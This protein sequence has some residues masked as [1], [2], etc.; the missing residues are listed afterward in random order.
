MQ[1][2]EKI[3]VEKLSKDLRLASALMSRDEARFLVDAYYQIQEH[4][5]AMQAQAQSLQKNDEPNAYMSYIGAQQEM[6]EEQIKKALGAYAKAQPAGKWAMSVCGIGPI[7][8]AGLLAYINPDEYQYIGS[9]LRFGG[10]DSSITWEKGE[11]RPWAAGLKVLFFKIGESFIKVQNRDSD[12]YGKF[13]R[14][15]K[16]VYL[17][18][19]ERGEHAK[20]AEAKLEKFKIGK[21]TEAYKAYSQGQLPPAHIHARARRKAVQLF[22]SHFCQVQWES[23]HKKPFPRPWVFV[24]P[25]RP[26]EQGSFVPPPGYEPLPR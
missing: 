24:H 1:M 3:E 25:D 10:Y 16:D 9:V 7:I 13:Y 12:F 17:W 2:L 19:N 26:H 11:K 5:I 23:H 22:I 8:S 4:R 14:K 18:R 15:W 20:A 21:T 6:L